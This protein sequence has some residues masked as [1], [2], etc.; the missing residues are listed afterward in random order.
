MSDVFAKPL[1]KLAG[2]TGEFYAFT[3]RHELRFQRCTACGRWRHV[4][5]VLCP[6]CAS[7]AWAWERSAGRG[8]VFTWSV[9]HRPMHP[10]FLEM[11]YATVVVEL[12]EGPRMLTTLI[13][14]APEELRAGLPVEV[15]F[16]DVTDEV[17]LPRFRRCG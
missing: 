10:A 2:L 13:D 3:K 4:P 1:P 12:A 11:P 7:D 6:D 16:D 14:V 9:T 15:V 8:T 5:R 17:T